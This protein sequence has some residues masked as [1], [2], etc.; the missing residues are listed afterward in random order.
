MSLG[1]N[2][3]R[4]ATRQRLEIVRLRREEKAL[5]DYPMKPPSMYAGTLL[6]KYMPCGKL[7][8]CCHAPSSKGHG[9]YFYVSIK[10]GNRYINKYLG[11]DKE[12][13]KLA[14]AFK[15]YV[16]RIACYRALQKEIDSLFIQIRDAGIIPW[17]EKRKH[18]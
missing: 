7:S 18:E 6:E 16:G 3:G 9:P 12:K 8:C 14:S 5:E 2:R 4:Q 15:E 11:R 10:M 17:K 1:K 13:I